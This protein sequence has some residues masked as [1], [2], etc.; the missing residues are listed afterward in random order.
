MFSYFSQKIKIKNFKVALFV[1]SSLFV[2]SFGL[3][4][5]ADDKNGVG[6]NIFNDTD[7]DGLSNDE[8]K[9]YGTDPNK[10]DTD[11]DGYSDGTEIRSGYDP[12]KSSP[13]DKINTVLDLEEQKV[14][15]SQKATTQDKVNLT[16]EVSR[17]V[18]ITLQE[19]K[20][21][22]ENLSLDILRSTIQKAMDEKITTDTLPE[23]DAKAIKIKKQKY[24]SLSETDR[25]AKIKEDTVN[26]ITAVSY[27]L[28]NNSPI[29][30][31]SEADMAKLGSFMTS[32]AMGVFSGGNSALLDDFTKKGALITEQLQ[33]V[34]V[35]ENM[36]EMHV[37]ALRL[38][39]YTTVLKEN[40]QS[41][42]SN[43]PLAQIS[44]F[45]KIQRFI[46]LFSE[47]T[48]DIQSVL[49]KNGIQEIP[50]NPVL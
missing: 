3:F 19:S 37:K 41:G 45:S 12:L 46:G 40:I 20:N 28:V 38:A 15:A 49:T 8:E 23:I 31:Q 17:Q 36:V 13:G 4:S 39:Q 6:K 29:L 44:Y 10:A 32:N 50:N 26:Y 14:S 25:A 21:N 24:A 9:L 30:M 42:D 16:E 1:F 5:F 33:S 48:H 22:K 7:Q 34:T 18:A 27:I 11:G 35:P 47:F 2:L 43:D